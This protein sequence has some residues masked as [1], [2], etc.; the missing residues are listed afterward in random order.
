MK[1]SWCINITH[2]KNIKFN[3]IFFNNLLTVDMWCIYL[4]EKKLMEII[5]HLNC[6]Q[7]YSTLVWCVIFVLLFSLYTI[8]FLTVILHIVKI[9]IV[10]CKWKMFWIS[11][12]WTNP[13]C[14]KEWK[15]ISLSFS[16]LYGYYLWLKPNTLIVFYLLSSFLWL[17]SEWLSGAFEC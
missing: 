5:K 13:R 1:T 8:V 2:N 11:D 4:K 7:N 12:C 16:S 15:G 6:I 14:L 10:E 3:L 17:K 9:I